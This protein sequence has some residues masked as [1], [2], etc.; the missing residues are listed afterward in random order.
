MQ[1]RGRRLSLALVAAFA[2]S[3]ASNAPAGAQETTHELRVRLEARSGVAVPG[4]LVALLSADGIAVA[5]GIS[6]E[7]GVRV[8]RAPAGSYRVRVRRIGFRPFTSTVVTLP[9]AG[10]LLLRVEFSPVV[11]SAVVVTAATQCARTD[12]DPALALVWDEVTKALRAT[13]LTREDLPDSIL[14]RS[15]H[16]EVLRDGT[17]LTADTTLVPLR[18]RRP[19]GAV[20]PAALVSAGYVF[21]SEDTGWELFGVDEKILL[22]NEFIATHCFRV[23]RHRERP[24]QIGIEFA[25]VRDRRLADVAGVLWL[26]EQSAELRELDYRYV[27]AGLLTTFRSTG[28]TRFRRMPSGAWLI[29]EWWLRMPLLERRMRGQRQEGVF[30]IGRVETGGDLLDAG[31]AV[32]ENVVAQLSA[33]DAGPPAPAQPSAAVSGHVVDAATRQPLS[34]ARIVIGTGGRTVVTA[35]DGAF[36]F[37]GLAAGAHVLWVRRIGYSL[38]RDTVRLREGETQ[39]IEIALGAQAVALAAVAVEAERTYLGG[40]W[41]RRDRD[42]GAFITRADI[43]RRK[44]M[45]LADM[46]YGLPGVKVEP[47]SGGGRVITST[48]HGDGSGCILAVF[49]NGVPY[50][51]SAYGIADFN[52]DDIEAIEVYSGPSRIPAQ[53][54]VT[55]GGGGGEI[56]GRPGCGVIALWLRG[57]P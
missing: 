56:Q 33:P 11:L 17:V 42:I 15:Y 20:N 21:G 51:M 19:F 37:A 32:E 53:F 52:Q 12:T 54:N 41:E 47:S 31:D 30:A 18:G 38:W 40:F 14:A 8:L 49:V 57:S 36:S 7:N 16:N 48:R 35:E 6:G 4:A 13:V 25:P 27:N 5:E 50:A 9:R 22:S 55:G 2:I 26:D 43:E 44:P 34:S 24:G 10:E 45:W 29:D 46:F 39:R 3:G 1:V 28:Y 23:V